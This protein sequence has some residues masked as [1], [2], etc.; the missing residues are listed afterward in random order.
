MVLP[1]AL[2]ITEVNHNDGRRDRKQ[3]I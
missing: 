3:T 1:V 2:T